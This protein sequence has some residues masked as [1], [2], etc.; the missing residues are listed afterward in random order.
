MP[1]YTDLPKPLSDVWEWQVHGLCR[2]VDSSMFFHPDGQRGRIRKQRELRAKQLCNRCPVLVQCREH[3]LTVEE[4]FG[5][6][7]G[8]SESERQAAI[9]HRRGDIAI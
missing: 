6:W 5:V 3:A 4:P 8:M 2:G 9:E 7:G 1:P